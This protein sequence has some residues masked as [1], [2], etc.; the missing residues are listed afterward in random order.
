MSKKKRHRYK[1]ETRRV[2]EIDCGQCSVCSQPL[3]KKGGYADSG[4]CGPC[5]TGEAA[6]L[7]ELGDE[8]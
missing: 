1:P 5:C 4:M 6:T 7:D 3:Y 8:W 2:E